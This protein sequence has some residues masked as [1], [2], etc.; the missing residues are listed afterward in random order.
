MASEGRR[1]RTVRVELDS[2]VFEALE[3][4]AEERST[5]LPQLISMLMR[6]HVEASR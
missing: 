4:E 3:D 6:E 2:E 5:I 1:K